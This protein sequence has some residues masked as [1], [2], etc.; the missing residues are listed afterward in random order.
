MRSPIPSQICPSFG[1]EQFSN[2]GPNSATTD[3]STPHPF[4]ILHPTHFSR[5]ARSPTISLPIR[6]RSSSQSK[7]ARL[8]PPLTSRFIHPRL[9]P[10][11]PRFRDAISRRPTSDE[12][13]RLTNSLNSGLVEAHLYCLAPSFFTHTSIAPPSSFRTAMRSPDIPAMLVSRIEQLERHIRASS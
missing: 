4:L 6:Y 3:V 12:G 13:S 8:A 9:S 1:S 5:S 7:A 11:E 10:P 2:D